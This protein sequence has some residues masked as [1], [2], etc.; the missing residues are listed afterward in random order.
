MVFR[1]N[2]KCLD[3]SSPLDFLSCLLLPHVSDCLLFHPLSPKPLY[4]RPHVA[5]LSLIA[6]AC[7]LG[8]SSC[9][10][11]CS[12]C[13]TFVPSPI[14]A[15]ASLFLPFALRS[16][17]WRSSLWIRQ[18]GVQIRSRTRFSRTALSFTSGSANCFMGV[19]L[20]SPTSITMKQC[21]SKQLLLPY[22]GHADWHLDAFGVASIE[23]FVA[24]GSNLKNSG[25]KLPISSTARL[26][27]TAHSGWKDIPK[28]CHSWFLQCVQSGQNDMIKC[29]SP[30]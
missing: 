25:D 16:S 2:S 1:S 30:C 13:A 6:R 29:S 7:G 22:G 28:F 11:I 24:I 23:L 12:V 3:I 10:L 5:S 20:R 26:P 14:V 19:L 27:R 21:A 17:S 8:C 18:K 4:V 9:C 15:S